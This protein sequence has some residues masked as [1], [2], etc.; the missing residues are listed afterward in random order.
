MRKNAGYRLDEAI[1]IYD[2]AEQ[3][4]I[5]VRFSDIPSMEG[6]LYCNPDPVIILSSLRPLGRRSFTCAHE[7]GHFHYGHGT[8][9]DKLVGKSIKTGFD[10]KEFAADCF[11]GALLMPKMAVQRA[12]FLRNWSMEGSTPGQIYSISN[13]FGV[14]Y[15]T[16][17]HHLSKS[18]RLLPG[19]R[20]EQLF[21]VGPRRAQAQAVGW[22]SDEKVWVVDPHWSGRAIDAEVGDLMLVRGEPDFEGNCI[23]RYDRWADGRL[24]RA[25]HPGIG[26]FREGSGW[27]AFARVSRRSFV[28]RSIFRHLPEG[29]DQ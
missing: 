18:L 16:L 19:P 12:F 11:A 7:L 6:M 17:I 14:G 13:Y 5:E 23:E 29:D 3:I 1:C 10:S 4:G 22:E 24:F 27:S 8:V 21:K 20:A 26:K 9:V 25:C 28:G 15:S 2:L